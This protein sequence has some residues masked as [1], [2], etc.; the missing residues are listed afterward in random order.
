MR[1]VLPAAFVVTLAFLV[2]ILI[3]QRQKSE[4]KQP[5]RPITSTPQPTS[6]PRTNN[7]RYSFAT[8]PPQI[9][10]SEKPIL[11][12]KRDMDREEEVISEDDI[13]RE[14]DLL[15]SSRDL[16]NALDAVEQW[17][18]KDLPPS[19]RERVAQYK[20]NLLLATGRVEDAY[21]VYWNIL[22]DGTRD[23]VRGWATAKLYVAAKQL[24]RVDG[25][26]VELEQLIAVDSGN[27]RLKQSLSD[28]YGYAGQTDKEINLRL[29]LFKA[30]VEDTNNGRKLIGA[31]QKTADHLA[32]A[33]I[34]GQMAKADL[35]YETYHL[36]RQAKSLIKAESFD[37]AQAVC[38]RI[39][40]SRRANA[41]TLLWC[42]Y[43]FEELG[44]LEKAEAAFEKG[45]E[46]AVE[47]YRKER[48]LV[49]ACKIRV[50]QG[51]LATNER[52]LLEDLAQNARATGVQK[53][54]KQ[55]LTENE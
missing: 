39:Y 11:S 1:W 27:L 28:M 37:D 42:G 9:S 20:G 18:A 4:E 54:A 32:V 5:E 44:Q 30:N 8:L 17:L 10:N 52:V 46:Q 26:I 53:L 25:L 34:S 15:I 43:S 41:Q 33:D 49:E 40:N 19:I 6:Q 31:Y 14:M 55:I 51:T 48:C 13:K 36:V 23:D 16:E 38:D 12:N 7:N 35:E 47:Q 21:A 45:A 22:Q 3:V 29:Q 2:I 24:K 50:G